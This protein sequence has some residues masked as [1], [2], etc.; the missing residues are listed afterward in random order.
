MIW[1]FYVSDDPEELVELLIIDFIQSIAIYVP[2]PSPI[3]LMKNSGIE[4][5]HTHSM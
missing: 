4:L 3:A 5:Q 2:N 1:G